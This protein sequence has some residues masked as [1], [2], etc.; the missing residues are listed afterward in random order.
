MIKGHENLPSIRAMLALERVA[1]L[2]NV[3]RAAEELNT[4]Q[5]AISRHLRQIEVELGVAVVARSGR[6]IILTPI[7]QTYAQ[8]VCETLSTL[9][10][11][12]RHAASNKNELII[13]CTHEVSHLILMPRYSD[14]KKKL[15]RDTHIRIITGEYQ[16]NP[17]MIDAGADIVFEY[18]RQRPQQMSAAIAI[19]EIVPAASPEFIKRNE[20]ALQSQPDKWHGLTRL[21]LTKANSG[22][23]TWENW[24]EH[25]GITPPAA[26]LN[27]FD[28]Y[29]YALEA[30]TRGE[31]LVLAW[32]GFAD[33]YLNSGQLVRVQPDWFKSGP[34]LYAVPTSNGAAKEVVRKCIKVL[35][36][37]RK[38]I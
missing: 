38:P 6:G 24:F 28:N 18:R 11:A 21:S 2:G 17:A 5:A 12:G 19:E 30:A 14:L 13:A 32:R 31:G 29:V 4:S 1:R 22:W 27:M 33:R 10:D 9:R 7:G 16:A 37:P 35:S 20:K 3:T 26:P 15:G 8:V 36:A 25:A 34:T 23:A